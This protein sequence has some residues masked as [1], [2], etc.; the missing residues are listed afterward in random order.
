MREKRKD[1][2]RRAILSVLALAPALRAVLG[3]AAQAQTA[4]TGDPLP[5]WN[6]GPAK[7]A[8]LKFVRATTDSSRPDFVRPEERIAEFDQDGTIWVEQ[9]LY[10]QVVFCLDRLGSVARAK[11]EIAK[12]EPFKTVLSGD[13]AGM[14][15]LAL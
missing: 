4:T 9:P 11:P 7:D 12:E 8:I 3:A 6:D 10:T 1:P 14:A 2:S 5:S 13:R 15:K